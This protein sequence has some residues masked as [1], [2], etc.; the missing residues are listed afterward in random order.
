MAKKSVIIC[1]DDER[2][3]LQSIKLQLKEFIGS[4]YLLET[5]ESGESALRLFNELVAEGREVPI[6]IVDY[7]MPGMRGDELLVNIH[8][9]STRTRCVMLTGQA[10]LTAVA[11]AINHECLF[12]YMA[13]PWAKE[14][15]VK[16][17]Q[18]ALHRYQLEK[19]LEEKNALLEKSNL[20]LDKV[21]NELK[22][23]LKLFYQFVPAE[24][25][26]CLGIDT[27][28]S[29]VELGESCQ[30]EVSALFIDIRSFTYHTQNLTNKET[31]VFVNS[32]IEQIAPIIKANHGF[33][34][35]FIGDEVLAIFLDVNDCLN[36]VFESSKKF[37][38]FSEGFR[39]H[40]VKLGFAVN[41]G[42]VQMGTVGYADRMETTILGKTVNIA[43]KIE[44]MNKT[45]KTE[46]I[47]TQNV[48]DTADQ[49]KFHFK[50]LDET[51]IPGIDQPLK[52]Y[53]GTAID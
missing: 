9:I 22:E 28:K 34:D 37:A 2:V 18:E 38:S 50:L 10:D 44:K 4:D 13:K 36:A 26:S 51:L 41:F 39:L 1:V 15:I 52:L 46:L 27:Q 33:I 5:A 30:K 25:L 8:K 23:R 43:A 11:N 19:Y 6:V 53:T 32:F 42:P 21:N 47:V 17:L 7:L 14:D 12:R 20:E 16:T 45:Y 3:I 24:F 48:V 40:G 31:F 49:N 35:K 29:H